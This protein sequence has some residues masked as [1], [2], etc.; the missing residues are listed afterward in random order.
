[1]AFDV[2]SEVLATLDLSSRLWFRAEL[3]A[4]FGVA[5]PEDRDVI[6]FH[7]AARGPCTV[8]LDRKPPLVFGPGDLVLIPHG[9]PH[10]LSDAPERPTTPLDSALD[11]SGFDGVG[12]L[13]LGGGGDVTVVVC[14]QFEFGRGALHPFVSSLPPLLH[15]VADDTISYGWIEQ[16]LQHIEREARTQVRGH[17][18]VIRRLSEIL[19]IEVLRARLRD[20]GLGALAALVDPQLGRALEA[21]HA[22]PEG[23]WSLESLARIAGQSRT[24]FAERFRDRV[25]VSPMKYLAAWRMQ[26]ARTLLARSGCSVGEVAR[27]VGYASESAFHRT[28]RDHF[29]VAPGALRRQ[30]SAA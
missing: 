29:G 1:M 20:P 14:G 24:L 11:A 30:Q 12:P 13:V 2:L 9:A 21:L 15:V 27:R 22:R 5:V 10:V 18:E 4:P 8:T 17:L 26:I 23:E 25:G 28:F 3:S 7:V 16:V 19:L 6:R